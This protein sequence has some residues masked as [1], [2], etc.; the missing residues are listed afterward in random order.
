MRLSWGEILGRI[1]VGITV[2]ALTPGAVGH[3][4]GSSE[5]PTLW[6]NC[7][8]SSKP[9]KNALISSSPLVAEKTGYRAWVQVASVAVPDGG[10]ECF[11]TTVLWISRGGNHPYRPVLTQLPVQPDLYG[12]GM[13]LV[14]WSP[15]GQLLLTELWQ[16][17]T[18][19]NDAPLAKR[20]LVF[21][22]GKN[23]KF[24]INLDAL[25]VD[26]KHKDCFVEFK[27]LG[28]TA[29]NWVALK[30]HITTFY[31]AD[32]T[33]ADKPA[34]KVCAEKTEVLAIDPYHT[35]PALNTRRFP[36]YQSHGS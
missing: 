22:P 9:P 24:E 17:N 4:A 32:E 10:A 18:M 5:S 27:L 14:D 36:D 26:Q 33:Q 34:G 8:Y 21:Q 20:I 35:N 19:P 30:A 1:T 11:N 31:E 13:Q 25:W 23:A 16:W 15:N 6:V 7:D 12:N 29:N 28:F 2:L 3:S